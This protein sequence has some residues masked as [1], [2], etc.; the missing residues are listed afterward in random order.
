MENTRVGPFLIFERLG[1]SRR[2]KVFRARQ[3]EQNIDVA[4]K[5]IGIPDETIRARAI[6][7]IQNEIEKLKELR[8]P[9]LVRTL[10]AGVEGE[11]V[12]FA[13]ELIK[14]ES[15]A[16]LLTRRGKLAADLVVDYGKQTAELLRYLHGQD[17]IHGK[18]T[19]DKILITRDGLVKVADMRLNRSKRK[20]L[21]RRRKLD[22]LA[23][24]APEQFQE[25]SSAKSDIYA[26][27]I[28]LFE[29]LTG[30]L[31]YPPE[32]LDKLAKLKLQAK[33]PSVLALKMDCPVWLDQLITKMISPDPRRRPHSTNAVIM[34]LDELK[35]FDRSKKATVDQVAGTFNPLTAGSDKSEADR[36]LGRSGRPVA[37][38][39]F[40]QSAGFLVG[41]LALILAI[42]IFAMIPASSEKLMANAR[43]LMASSEPADWLEARNDLKEVMTRGSDNEHYGEAENLYFESRRRSL[44][45]QAQNGR[46]IAL[47]SAASQKF[48]D[49]VRLQANREYDLA[50]ATFQELVDSV[51]AQGDERH[52]HW[53]SSSRIDKIRKTTANDKLGPLLDKVKSLRE[54]QTT[55]ELESSIE[56]LTRIMKEH[57]DKPEFQPVV[58]LA[59]EV[60][61]EN[62]T[63]LQQQ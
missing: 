40:F 13:T 2:Q 33:P 60:L 38:H 15:L 17:L 54:A 31:P 37:E 10:G 59:E 29:L 52:I 19:P 5:F 42:L 12:F 57:Q 43:N 23:Y 46:K 44:V 55:D 20:K 27:G 1:T 36:L 9:N 47:Q 48:V 62:Q 34:A 4:I 28:I 26:L 18:L 14:S 11:Q 39:S 58:T 3:I 24:L 16:K 50:K 53:E 7:K 63:R 22:D 32:T 8:H 6:D 21:S 45:M 35:K 41:S 25:G 49:A 30:K 56:L 51:D 61:A